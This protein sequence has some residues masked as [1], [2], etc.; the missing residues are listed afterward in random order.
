[1]TAAMVDRGEKPSVISALLKYRTTEAMRDRYNDA[2]DN[3]G[4]RAV[5][6]QAGA[7]I[8]YSTGIPKLLEELQ[9]FQPSF[10]LAVPRVFEMQ[11]SFRTGPSGWV[12]RQCS[13]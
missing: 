8:A 13:T 3:H 9:M 6:V 7:T 12:R 5:H 1:M 2:M 10:L 4:G 11:G